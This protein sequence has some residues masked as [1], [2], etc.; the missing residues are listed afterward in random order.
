[1]AVSGLRSRPQ[2]PI[3]RNWGFDCLPVPFRNPREP[4]PYWGRKLSHSL[5]EKHRR[6][7]PRLFVSAGIGQVLVFAKNDSSVLARMH[8]HETTEIADDLA[9]T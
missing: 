4:G 9:V 6:D 1:M 5:Q 7:R 3:Y 2:T 8:S